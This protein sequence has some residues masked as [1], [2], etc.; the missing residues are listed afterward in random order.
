MHD[1]YNHKTVCNNI[2]VYLI[3]G[4]CT[5][6]MKAQLVLFKCTDKETPMKF[7]ITISLTPILF[8][9]IE[10]IHVL[11]VNTH[12]TLSRLLKK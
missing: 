1:I 2:L 10:R 5:C 11:N 3:T 8:N 4:T 6:T 7:N 12:C 9:F